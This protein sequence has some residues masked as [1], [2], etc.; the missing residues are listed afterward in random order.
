MAL[1]ARSAISRRATRPGPAGRAGERHRASSGGAARAEVARGHQRGPEQATRLDL[2]A[3][4]LSERPLTECGPDIGREI[5]RDPPYRRPFRSHAA[6]AI[7]A[8]RSRA[9]GRGRNLFRVVAALSASG[10]AARAR[11]RAIPGGLARAPC[12][13]WS[14][15]PRRTRPGSALARS[16]PRRAGSSGSSDQSAH[17]SAAAA[18]RRQARIPARGVI[19]VRGDTP[20]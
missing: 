20:P 5:E 14:S 12:Q 17:P 18:A 19:T 8:A 7:H 13:A 1:V 11:R 10:V 15:H 9:G 6:D 16:P 3:P 4:F 2:D